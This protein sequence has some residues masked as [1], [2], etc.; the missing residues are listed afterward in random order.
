MF[1]F[2]NEFHQFLSK[3]ITLIFTGFFGFSSLV[4]GI[5][6]DFPQVPEDFSPTLRFAVC[7][8]V[9]LKEKETDE[10]S[11]NFGKDNQDKFRDTIEKAYQLTGDSLDAFIIAGDFTDNGKKEEFEIFKSITDESIKESTE[12]L[13]CLGNH[14]FNVYRDNKEPQKAYEIYKQ[15]VNENVDTH[16][17]IGGYH[18]IGVSY[19]NN[20]KE[21]FLTK[22]S[23]LKKELD[24]AVADTGDKPIF[25]FQHPHP[26]M[27]V[28]GSVNW[29]NVEIR[30]VL[31][32]YPQVVDFSGHSHYAAN[33]PRSLWQGSFTAVGCGAV[34]GSMG[35][36]SYI[37]GDAYGDGDSASFWLVEVDA[38]GSVRMRAYDVVS[39]CF[40]PESD[41]YLTNLTCKTKR[42]YTWGNK[43]LTDTAPAFPENAKIS[44]T[45]ADDG[46][47]EISFPEASGYYRAENYKIA[48]GKGGVAVK[49]FVV[50]SDYT[51]ATDF[52][53]TVNLGV[54][55]KGRYNIEITAYSPYAKKGETIKL[56]FE[57]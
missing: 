33:D 9:H 51:R 44:L 46:S 47:A 23:W 10:N 1:S 34:T 31:N 15:Y 22:T 29:G 24:K 4:S 57:I 16:T 14:E 27:T 7:S 21:T 37:S 13:V 38:Q 56:I 40:F 5:N 53:K 30:S 41:Y 55:E 25:V 32:M 52:E 48:V 6:K 49:S 45:L 20:G 3:A 17:V 42:A 26:E 50:L 18:F 35:N 12:L 19:D 39:D 8:D 43:Y 36:L 54:L 2:N 11:E 28:Y